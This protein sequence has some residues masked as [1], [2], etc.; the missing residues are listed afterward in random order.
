MKVD[1]GKGRR[2]EDSDIALLN[3]P[4]GLWLRGNGRGLSILQ[5]RAVPGHYLHLSSCLFP[6]A[7]SGGESY[8]YEVLRGAGL[9]LAV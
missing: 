3:E 6:L 2:Q 9:V 5:G 4:K 7:L 1:P 8:V